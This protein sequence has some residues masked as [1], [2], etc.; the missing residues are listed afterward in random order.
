MLNESLRRKPLTLSGECPEMSVQDQMAK[1]FTRQAK[2]GR[3]ALMAAFRLFQT[4]LFKINTCPEAPNVPKEQR[5]LFAL[6]FRERALPSSEVLGEAG[7]KV[8]RSHSLPHPTPTSPPLASVRHLR[9]F[10]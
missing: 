6:L 8:P 3:F 9:D 7:C 10:C 2:V 4:L 5:V 1:G